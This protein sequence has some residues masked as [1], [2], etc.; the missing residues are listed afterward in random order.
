M[1]YSHYLY[2]KQKLNRKVFKAFSEDV[3][4]ALYA[5][6]IPL[7]YR[8]NGVKV[9]GF[10]ADESVINF[11][12][13]GLNGHEN[14]YMLANFEPTQYD[15][16]DDDKYFCFC[17][18]AEKPY[19]VCVVATLIL[20]KLHFGDDVKV[21]SDGKKEEWED[22]LQLAKKVLNGHLSMDLD[23]LGLTVYF[24]ENTPPPPP[25]DPSITESEREAL[26]K[27]ELYD[28]IG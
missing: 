19:D 26:K 20:A 5:S 22:G 2:R 3:K 7:S 15:I 25:K 12:G 9:D 8:A 23:D 10:Q 6:G 28:L 27:S 24:K 4:K 11:N 18:T 21:T 17:K 16:K 14:F 1:G 13:V